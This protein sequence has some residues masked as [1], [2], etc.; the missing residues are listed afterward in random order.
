[1]FY[2]VSSDVKQ[3]SQLLWTKSQASGRQVIETEWIHSGFG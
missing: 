3:R 2:A 1:M